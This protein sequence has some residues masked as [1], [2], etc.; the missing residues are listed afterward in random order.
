MARAQKI[1]IIN[2]LLSSLDGKIATHQQES[3]AQRRLLK[4]TNDDDFNH[5]QKL[6]ATC[7][8]VL[9][10]ARTL[11][12]EIGAFRV[13][14]LRKDGNEPHWF[15]MTKSGKINLEHPFWTQ[16]KISKS[17]F[18]FS[19][20][21]SVFEFLDLLHQKK[22]KT[23][24]LLGGGELNGFFWEHDLVSELHLT[25]S[26]FI[27]GAQNAPSLIKTTHPLHKKLKLVNVT[28][29]KNFLFLHYK[30]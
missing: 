17:V 21:S 1:K 3:S 27:I 6:T 25:I 30:K 8:A 18:Y 7:D 2:I 29:K 28:Q 14:H 4:W 26:P 5:M 20:L 22:M 12:S 13:A 11:H 24:A 23:V 9:I 15:V 19:G 16:E 10:G